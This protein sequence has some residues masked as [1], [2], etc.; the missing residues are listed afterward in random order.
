MSQQLYIILETYPGKSLYSSNITDHHYYSSA[1]RALEVAKENAELILEQTKQNYVHPENLEI[2]QIYD[3]ND[4]YDE[5]IQGYAVM[6]V[7]SDV[8]KAWLEVLA[9]TPEN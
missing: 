4:N 8:P 5:S 6:D 9:I 2:N 7:N 1:D 3:N